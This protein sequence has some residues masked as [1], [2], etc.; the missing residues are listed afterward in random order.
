MGAMASQITSL[1]MVFSTVLSGANQ[2]K[3]QS[4]ASL[5]F[6][7]GIHRWPVNNSPHKRPVTWKMFPSDDVILFNFFSSSLLRLAAK[8]SSMSK[9]L[10]ELHPPDIGGFHAQYKCTDIQVNRYEKRQL[11]LL[12]AR[13]QVELLFHP[14]GSKQFAHNWISDQ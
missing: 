6:V 10:Y 12:A 2:I 14:A 13:K 1:M 7:R 8:K 3:H 5:S 11:F 4:S 9:V